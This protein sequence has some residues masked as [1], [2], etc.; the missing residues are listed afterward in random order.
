MLT[1]ALSSGVIG[2]E[3]LTIAIFM[4][5]VTT[6]LTPPLLKLAYKH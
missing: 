4:V 3:A 5:F 2:S 1:I 6:M